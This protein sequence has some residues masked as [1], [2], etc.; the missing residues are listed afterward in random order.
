MNLDFNNG[1]QVSGYNIFDESKIV[2]VFITL[3]SSSLYDY[4]NVFL[5][6]KTFYWFSKNN[7]VLER[8]GKITKEGLI[9]ENYYTVQV[10]LKKSNSEN[11]YYLGEVK[12]VKSAEMKVKENGGPLV[13]YLFELENEI[14]EWLFNYMV[15]K[16]KI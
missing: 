10:F 7:R 8:N 12:E 2:T 1:L 16:E 9:G 11:Y 6:S 4:N 13:E 15:L 3:D 14:E 5:D